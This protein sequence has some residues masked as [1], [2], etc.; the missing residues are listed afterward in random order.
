MNS[1]R[2]SRF[3]T[4]P[5][6]L[7][8]FIVAACAGIIVGIYALRSRGIEMPAELMACLPRSRATLAYVDV[9]ALRRSG[10]LDLIAGSKAA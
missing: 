2:V 4:Q 6:H 8:A 3:R 5:W 7:A 9:N 10:F 1:R